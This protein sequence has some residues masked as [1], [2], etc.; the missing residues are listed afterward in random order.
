MTGG[1]DLSIGRSDMACRLQHREPVVRQ[2]AAAALGALGALGP[3]ELTA[4]RALLQDPD[5]GVRRAAAIALQKG[6]S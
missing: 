5:Q 4:L 1:H 2:A 6:A 3:P